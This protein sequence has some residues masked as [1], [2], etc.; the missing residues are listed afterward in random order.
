M[1]KIAD[2]Q[3]EQQFNYIAHLERV[4]KQIKGEAEENGEALIVELVNIGLSYKE[5]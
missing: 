4:L 1:G 5:E 2:K 3:I